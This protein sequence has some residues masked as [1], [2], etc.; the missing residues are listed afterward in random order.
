M[1]NFK[2]LTLGV[3]LAFAVLI[4]PSIASAQSI[5]VDP[6]SH[7]Y[8]NVA[9]GESRSMVFVISSTAT[10]ELTIETISVDDPGGTFV[11]T[12][13][14][15]SGLIILPGGT[16]MEVNV[17]FTPPDAGPFS[18][19]LHVLSDAEPSH[20]YFPLNGEGCIDDCTNAG[21][22]MADTI[23][24]FNDAVADGTLD[25]DGP[26]DRAAGNRL[27]AFG[28]M[29]DSANELIELGEVDLACD[30][31]LSAYRKADGEAPPPDFVNGESQEQLAG[32]LL[33]VMGDLGC[34]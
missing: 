2:L 3:F 21:E 10:T 1:K 31:L 20:L 25:G 19:N 28:N 29:L 17:T 23:A 12:D 18:A 15:T 27:R 6:M 11:C 33:D 9:L 34:P 16:S 26:T 13:C 24:F 4:A 22:L 32:M 8:G 7:D 5:E 30:Q 14:P